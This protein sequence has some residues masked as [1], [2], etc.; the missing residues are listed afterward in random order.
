MNERS[1]NE[2]GWGDVVLGIA[3]LVS[4]SLMVPTINMKAPIANQMKAT[5]NCKQIITA[6]LVY[7]SD[8]NGKYPTGG[9]AN[10]TFRKLIVADILQDERLFG[11]PSSPFVPDVNV[12]TSPDFLD[13]V[14]RGENHWMLVD[15]LRDDSSGEAPLVFENALDA[16]WPPVWDGSLYNGVRKRGQTWKGGRIVVGN[17]D[18][19]VSVEKLSGKDQRRLSFDPA[20]WQKLMES[21]PQ[22][23]VLD[24]EE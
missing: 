20:T 17:N 6:M 23:R 21:I 9:T 2:W 8:H 22:A 14:G 10:E 16:S 12:G 18:S 5:S 13:A 11:C 19:S 24:I 4:L 7:A 3:V 15:G 1:Q